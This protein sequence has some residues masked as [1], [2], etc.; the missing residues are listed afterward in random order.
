MAWQPIDTAPWDE[1]ILVRGP[2]GVILVEGRDADWWAVCEGE[3]VYDCA[4][5]SAY[6]VTATAPT[7]WH[8]IPD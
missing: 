4:D 8:P 5:E 3:Y 6:M 2:A 1:P 7:E